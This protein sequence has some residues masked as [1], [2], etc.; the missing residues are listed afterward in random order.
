MNEKYCYQLICE[1]LKIERPLTG[2]IEERESWKAELQSR[3]EEVKKLFENDGEKFKAAFQGLAVENFQ[4]ISNCVTNY[5][6]LID[7]IEKF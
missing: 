1:A 5:K 3:I 6:K 2:T 7:E 4:N